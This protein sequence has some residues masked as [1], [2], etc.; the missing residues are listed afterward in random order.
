MFLKVKYAFLLFIQNNLEHFDT[1]VKIF[2]LWGQ[3]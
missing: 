1:P 2:D 3:N